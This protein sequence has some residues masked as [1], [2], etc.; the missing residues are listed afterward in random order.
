MCADV[1]TL[2]VDIDGVV[3]AV[4]ADSEG[5]V[6]FLKSLSLVCR[7]TADFHVYC[8]SRRNLVMRNCMHCSVAGIVVGN[9]GTA[10]AILAGIVAEPVDNVGLGIDIVH[11]MTD[12]LLVAAGHDA[13]HLGYSLS[14]MN[15]CIRL[16]V[17]TD[18]RWI[19]EFE[20]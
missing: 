3:A 10:I 4:V 7:M 2:T 17:W 12:G 18:I 1:R 8:M 15:E 13:P 19:V 14:A 9:D 5:H 6:A 20:R 11:R 16:F